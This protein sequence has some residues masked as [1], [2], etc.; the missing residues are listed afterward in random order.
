VFPWSHTVFLENETVEIANHFAS[1][2]K[3]GDVVLLNGKL[4]S[5]KTFFVKNVC[6]NF[7]I[8]NVSS[9]S[10]SIV[11]EYEGAYKIFHFDFY[12]V[13]KAEELED[14]GFDDYLND[15][16]AIVFIEWAEMFEKMLPRNHYKINFQIITDGKR[17]IKID[18][19]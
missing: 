14:I 8:Q 1:E 3:P 15:S 11:N 5:G 4:G 10:F 13:E 18:K 17:E 19:I 7:G 6:M 2:L 16:E 12:R 9:P